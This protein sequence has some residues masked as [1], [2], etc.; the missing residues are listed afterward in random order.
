MVHFE[1]SF[2]YHLIRAIMT[3]NRI[4]PHITDD[5]S[6]PPEKY[7]PIENDMMW[8]VLVRDIYPDAGNEEILGCWVLHPHNTICWEIHTCL[9][10]NA[11]GERGQQAARLL[12]QWIWENTPCRRIITNV[13]TTNRLALHFAFKAGMKAFGVNEASYLK[14][15]KLCDQVMLGISAPAQYAPQ[16]RE[17]AQ[18][19]IAA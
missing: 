9:L 18:E 5:Y 2:D 15:D 11:W 19:F 4:Y 1:R 17:E 10:P 3:H 7:R 6:P 12:P 13:P 8:Y 16:S 14:N